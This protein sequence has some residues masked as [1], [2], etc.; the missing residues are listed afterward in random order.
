MKSVPLIAEENAS[1]DE[2]DKLAVLEKKSDHLTLL[3]QKN[4]NRVHLVFYHL[5]RKLHRLA[6]KLA[7][8]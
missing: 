4:K 8:Y 6:A 7:K 2:M 1:H 3:Q 5:A